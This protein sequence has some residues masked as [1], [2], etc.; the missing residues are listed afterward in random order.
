[1]KQREAETCDQDVRPVNGGP[2]DRSEGPKPFT[3]GAVPLP[4]IQKAP[5]GGLPALTANQISSLFGSILS[6]Q[7]S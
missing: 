7:D 2:G 6:P 3:E 1:M 5:L 4:D